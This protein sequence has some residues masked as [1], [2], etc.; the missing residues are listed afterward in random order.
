[1]R[2]LIFVV[3]FSVAADL[4][5]PK[6]SVLGARFEEPSP[7]VKGMGLLQEATVPF[8]IVAWICDGQRT[9]EFYVAV[10]FELAQGNYLY[11][12]TQAC[13]L[14]TKLEVALDRNLIISGPFYSSAPP[15]SAHDAALDM[16]IEKH[17]GQIV[18]YVPI[19]CTG[20]VDR[21]RLLV[22]VRINGQVCSDAGACIPIR[23]HVIEARWQP[24]R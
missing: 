6:Q 1:M 9:D 16:T 14:A 4:G 11:S 17:L 7:R 5:Y 18:F 12:L 21:N 13:D 22:P 3:C 2:W 24:V 19:R 10:R 15:S 23:N 8:H 20:P